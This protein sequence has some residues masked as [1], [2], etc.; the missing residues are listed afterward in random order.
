MW[1]VM[2][3]HA[4]ELVGGLGY[5]QVVNDPFYT[6]R[7][8][9]ARLEARPVDWLGVGAAGGWYPYGGEDTWSPLAKSLLHE[10][11]ISPDV[12]SI[13]SSLG[14][15]V[16]VAPFRGVV[17]SWSS[18]VGLTAGVGAVH[19][20]DDLVALQAVGEPQFEATSEQFHPFGS[21]GVFGE[22]RRGVWG[23]RLGIDRMSYVEVIGTET[24]EDKNPVWVGM[25]LALWPQ[26]RTR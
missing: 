25:E 3:A 11:S 12:S 26:V 21:V 18:R 5:A 23:G 4:F 8:P 6:P 17:G 20:V 7:G 15:L 19:T 10:Q 2:T 9:A 13:T 24:K 22:L 16:T 14:V 1:L